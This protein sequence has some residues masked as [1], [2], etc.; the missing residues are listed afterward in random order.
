MLNGYSFSRRSLQKLNTCDSKIINVMTLAI[1]VSEVDFGITEGTRTLA[2]QQK[3]FAEGRSKCDGI[4][5]KSR[6][7]SN[8]SEAVDFYCWV[9]GKINYEDKYM[10]YVAGIIFNLGFQIGIDLEWGGLWR[11]FKDTPHIQ[12]KTKINK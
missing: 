8:P 7:Q 6:H 11:N 12:L 5:D 10:G 9:N 3:Y 2:T 1:K 4:T